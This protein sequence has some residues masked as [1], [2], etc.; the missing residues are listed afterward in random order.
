MVTFQRPNE[1]NYSEK[2]LSC[3]RPPSP[4]PRPKE[5]TMSRVKHGIKDKVTS[6]KSHFH[7][8]QESS[9]VPMLG[10]GKQGAGFY[11]IDGLDGRQDSGVRVGEQ[12]SGHVREHSER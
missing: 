2:F 11:A 4:C 1:T 9:K 7:R 3:R 5:P 10:N 8:H 6:V 12:R